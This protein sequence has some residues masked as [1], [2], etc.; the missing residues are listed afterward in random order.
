MKV[1]LRFPVY[2]HLDRQLSRWWAWLEGSRPDW[3]KQG[4]CF[5]S[6]D[7][8]YCTAGPD[9]ARNV[10]VLEFLKTDATHLWM[11]DCDTLPPYHLAILEE[12]RDKEASVISGVYDRYWDELGICAPQVYMKVPDEPGKPPGRWR[13][14][15][16]AQWPTGSLIK[17]DAVGTGCLVIRR[18]V[19]EQMAW[20]YFEI[21]QL[22]GQELRGEDF[23]FCSK[24]GGVAVMPVYVCKHFRDVDLSKYRE[25]CEYLGTANLELRQVRAEVERLKGKGRRGG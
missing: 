20:P 23:V 9:R 18:D 4:I 14:V 11:V 21:I 13:T 6:I 2:D 17:A 1:F 16:R 22:P 10:C 5:H 7:Y 15:D 24:V 19:L 3:E 8:V 25:L 12:A